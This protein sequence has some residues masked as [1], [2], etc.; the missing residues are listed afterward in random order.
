MCDRFSNIDPNVVLKCVTF[1]LSEIYRREPELKKRA[2][3]TEAVQRSVRENAQKNI[4]IENAYLN[5]PEYGLVPEKPVFVNGFG[6][7]KEYLSHLYAED[8][9]KLS[10]A[11]VGSSEVNGIAGPVDLYS[12]LLPD[13]TEYLRLFVCNY[14]ST[15]KRIVPK[16]TIYVD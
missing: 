8:G 5:D 7:D 11:R 13:D 10:F 14:G 6:M 12:L 16:G 4:F 15:M 2:E 3:A 9:T 1:S